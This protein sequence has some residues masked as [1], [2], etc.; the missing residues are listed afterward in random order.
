MSRAGGHTSLRV[1]L[2]HAL[3]RA[4]DDDHLAVEFSHWRTPKSDRAHAY[5]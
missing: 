5:Y 2:A 1:A 4:G 3:C